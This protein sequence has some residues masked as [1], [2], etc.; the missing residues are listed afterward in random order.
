VFLDGKRIGTGILRT[1]IPA[2]DHRVEVRLGGAR[3][4]ERFSVAPGETWTYVV[5]P[6]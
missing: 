2:G 4:G 1:Q 3:V 6:E 5:N